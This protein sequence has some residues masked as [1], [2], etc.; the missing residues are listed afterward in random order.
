[1][2]KDNIIFKQLKRKQTKIEIDIKHIIANF[3]LFNIPENNTLKKG[4]ITIIKVK[5]T[6]DLREAVILFIIREDMQSKLKIINKILISTVKD[7]KS[8]ISKSMKLKFIPNLKFK[9]DKNFDEANR[10]YSIIQKIGI[11]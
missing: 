3:L 8:I 9:Y 7:I 2:N 1:M 11:L 6:P 5:I 4:C 10:V